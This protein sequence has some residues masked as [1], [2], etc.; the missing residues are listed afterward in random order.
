MQL[1]PRNDYVLVE[2][3]QRPEVTA[4][5]GFGLDSDSVKDRQKGTVLDAG[6]GR[7]TSQGE[8][9]PIELPKG[10]RVWLFPGHGQKVDDNEDILLL[11]EDSILGIIDDEI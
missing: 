10:T 9:V 2:L 3:D 4:S 1:K 7:L 5:G 8:R 11:R 6:P